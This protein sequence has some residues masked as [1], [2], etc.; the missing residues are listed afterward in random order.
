[1]QVPKDHKPRKPRVKK[2][3][4]LKRVPE[5]AMPEQA[6]A[7]EAQYTSAELAVLAEARTFVEELGPGM[8][9]A[10]VQLVQALLSVDEEGYGALTKRAVMAYQAGNPLIAKMDGFV[11]AETWQQLFA[12][13]LSRANN[14]E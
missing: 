7:I 1:M 4:V 11:T 2:E 9:N 13:K 6:K 5:E 10:Q 14:E 12:L 8:D 3:P